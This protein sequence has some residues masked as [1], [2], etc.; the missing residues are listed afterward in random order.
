MVVRPAAP[1]FRPVTLGPKD[2]FGPASHDATWRASSVLIAQPSNLGIVG[3]G[4]RGTYGAGEAADDDDRRPV[5]SRRVTFEDAEQ[6]IQPSTRAARSSLAETSHRAVHR[7][8]HPAA[9]EPRW[10]GDG[11][12]IDDLDEIFADG[13][14]HASKNA[15]AGQLSS[16]IVVM[17][18]LK[19]LDVPGRIHRRLPR[20]GWRRLVQSSD[21]VGV[22]FAF[23]LSVRPNLD[24]QVKRDEE[25]RQSS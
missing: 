25:D 18:P 7:F 14:R 16:R 20:D 19:A 24:L 12:G 22:P 2:V 9:W 23:F 13:Q 15:S 17:M 3:V 10:R 5:E 4:K 8:P 1:Q 21:S 6:P 11:D